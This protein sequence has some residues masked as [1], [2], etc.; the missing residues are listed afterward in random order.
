MTEVL[1]GHHLV[2][3]PSVDRSDLPGDAEIISAARNIGQTMALV[4]AAAA[5]QH[6][7]WTVTRPNLEDVVL[8]YMSR[9]GEERHRSRSSGGSAMTRLTFRQFRA[10]AIT[11]LAAV[12]VL[13]VA[14]GY[15]GPRLADLYSKSGLRGCSDGTPA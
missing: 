9:A 10:Q 13:A 11:A 3:G 15:T 6:P 1:D 12:A 8:G 2:S 7:A 14:Y 4:R 5:P